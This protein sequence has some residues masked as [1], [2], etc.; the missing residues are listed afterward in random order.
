MALDTGNGAVIA[1]TTSGFS[2]AFITINGAE[3]EIPDINIS[4]LETTVSEKFRPGDLIN[5]GEFDCEFFWNGATTPPTV[6]QPG[7]TILHETITVTGPTPPGGA[8]GPIWIGKGYIKK[9]KTADY[10]NNEMQKGKITVKWTGY[11]SD[12]V[13]NGPAYTVAT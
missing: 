3:F 1:F 13:S 5:R 2:A 7:A 8:S 12:G 6:G 11:A 9:L 10:Q 4:H